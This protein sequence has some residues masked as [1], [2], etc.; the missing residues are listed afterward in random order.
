MVGQRLQQLDN[1]VFKYGF[2][3]LIP[4]ILNKKN[5]IFLDLLLFNIEKKCYNMLLKYFDSFSGGHDE[6]MAQKASF[7]N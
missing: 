4:K 5:Y 6:R 2:I 3:C 1:I 7:S